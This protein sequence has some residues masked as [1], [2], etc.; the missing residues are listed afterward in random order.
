MRVRPEPWY[1]E[2]QYQADLTRGKKIFK[3]CA[4]CEEPIYYGDYYVENEEG[5]FHEECA[6]DYYLRWV[7]ENARKEE[8]P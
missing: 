7:K 4:E 5:F 6:E 8:E 2:M 1:E 3:I